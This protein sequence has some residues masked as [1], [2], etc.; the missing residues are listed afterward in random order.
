MIGLHLY[1]G[2]FK[3]IPFDQKN[4]LKEAFNIRLEE[5]MVMDIKFLYG[6]AEPTIALIHE[7]TKVLS[8]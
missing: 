5:L 8:A 2:L 1:D 7:D 6:C 4:Q 3:V